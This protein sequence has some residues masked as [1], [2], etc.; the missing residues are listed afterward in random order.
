MSWL[1]RKLAARYGLAADF[2]VAEWATAWTVDGLPPVGADASG[3]IIDPDLSASI[4]EWKVAG[5]RTDVSANVE[6]TTLTIR[7]R[8]STAGRVPALNEP[9][10]L[11]LGGALATAL[12]LPEAD[13][14]RFTGEVTGRWITGDVLTVTAVGR[15]S[16][17]GSLYVGDEPWPTELDGDRALRILQLAEAQL[18]DLQL[19]DV[20]PGTAFVLARDVDRQPALGL[21][22]SLGLSADGQLVETRTGALEWHDADHRRFAPVA[23]ELRPAELLAD[24]EW[25]ST[26]E[27]MVN[28]VTVV[29]GT[30][31][32]SGR[33]E[34]TATDTAA[35]GPLGSGPLAAQLDTELAN[36]DD[37]VSRASLLVNRRSTEWWATPALTVELVRTLT[38]SK[39]AA[40]LSLAHGTPIYVA[41]LPS[42]HPLQSGRLMVE[43]YAETMTPRG[44]AMELAVADAG[45]AAPPIRWVDV[46]T[47]V[48]WAEVEPHVT[49]AWCA[50]WVPDEP[51]L[52]GRW[53]DQP[54]DLAWSDVPL[55]DTWATY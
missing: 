42:L 29:Y 34:F 55:V 53:A 46:P 33:P 26:R 21:L 25:S 24:L 1:Q 30:D 11:L 12:G 9:M 52:L 31:P 28:T 16:R 49:W 32:G 5:G 17:L 48:S 14:A 54:A 15:R 13:R 3:H 51:A 38:A 39:L 45:M 41:G 40:M 18:S 50:R 43:G 4:S 36:L 2:T 22:E 44:W 7:L 6:A 10:R 23:L 35:A 37:A 20:D 47:D 27:G 19:G 8:H